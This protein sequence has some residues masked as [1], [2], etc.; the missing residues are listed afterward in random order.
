MGIRTVGLRLAAV[1]ALFVSSGPATAAEAAAPAA[2]SGTV[3]ITPTS[4]S[5]TSSG[6]V[7]IVN[8]GYTGFHTVCLSNGLVV[9]ASLSGQLVETIRSS[10]VTNYRFA[11]VA[12][13]GGGSLAYRGDASLTAGGWQSAV[14]TVGQGTGPLAGIVGQG[15]FW[16]TSATTFDDVIYYTYH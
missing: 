10:G 5:S 12:S 9:T 1:A 6:P 8:I 13:Y 16:P 3:V 14:R 7:T 11:E 15:R 4:V 2:C